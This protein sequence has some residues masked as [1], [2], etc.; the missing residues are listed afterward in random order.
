MNINYVIGNAVKPGR[1]DTHRVIAHICN[2]EGGW[3]SGFV[4]ALNSEF[5]PSRD[6]AKYVDGQNVFN[7]PEAKYRDWS[8]SKKKG[9]FVLGQIQLVYVKEGITVCNMIAQ[10]STGGLYETFYKDGRIAS[11]VKLPVPNVN[12]SSL[13]EC[14][15]RLKTRLTLD[16]KSDKMLTTI[17]CP[18]MGAGLGGGNWNKVEK[19][20][21]EAFKDT[22]FEI[23][24]YDLE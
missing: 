21:K 1:E 17:H 23:Y 5:T 11:K 15:I 9:D 4:L 24:V 14:L 8:K 2:D 18:R 12:Y 19:V 7:S 6:T 20:I 13:L 10:R 16:W 3:G 22:D